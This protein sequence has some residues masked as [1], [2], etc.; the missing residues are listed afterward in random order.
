MTEPVDQRA[1]VL[2]VL[3]RLVPGGRAFPPLHRALPVPRVGD[4]CPRLARWKATGP[5]EFL[6]PRG[7]PRH[8]AKVHKTMSSA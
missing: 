7:A 6:N 1:A 4:G 8:P 2:E 5:D 3:A